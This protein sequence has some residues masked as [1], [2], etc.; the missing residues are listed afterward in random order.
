MTIVFK[1]SEKLKEKM[2]N[3]YENLKSVALK[4]AVEAAGDAEISGKNF[5]FFEEDGRYTVWAEVYAEVR[6]DFYKNGG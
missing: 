2:I 1:V 4:K 5:G 3:Y 6:I